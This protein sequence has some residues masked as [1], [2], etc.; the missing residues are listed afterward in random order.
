MTTNPLIAFAMLSVNWDDHGVSYTHNYLP[1]V[2]YCLSNI[3][4]NHTDDTTLQELIEQHFG[5]RLPIPVIRTVTRR[6]A[7]E[8]LLTRKH[9][10]LIPIP[11]KIEQF[12]FHDKR[13]QVTHD[14]EVL[15]DHYLSYLADTTYSSLTRSEAEHALFSYIADRSLPILRA[16]IR[17]T[18]IDLGELP[19]T[20]YAYITSRFIVQMHDTDRG[21]F[22]LIERVVKGSML[23]SAI[24]L[25]NHDKLNRRI[26]NLTIYLDTPYLIELLGLTHP[27]T[28]DAARELFELLL[29][30][31]ARIACFEHT[32]L[33][34][35]GVMRGAAIQLR[36]LK[37][38]PGQ[39][40]VSPPLVEHSISS[41]LQSTELEVRAE[42]LATEL[43]DLGVRVLES[44]NYLDALSVDEL[45]MEKLL[46]RHVGYRNENTRYRD[47]QS[48]TAIYR[49]RG[50]QEKGTLEHAIAIFVTPNGN[51]AR[52][53]REFFGEH[54]QGDLVPIC[55]LDS[56][57]A[58]V[59]WLKKP[60]ESPD[61]PR[62]QLIADCYAAG[63]PDE[64]LWTR[65]LDEIDRLE[66]QE[67]FTEDMYFTLRYSVEARR[68]LMDMTQ[69]ASSRVNPQVISEVLTRVEQE[70]AAPVKEA[71]ERER[72]HRERLQEELQGVQDEL[73]NR[74]D[75]NEAATRAFAQVCRAQSDKL[76]R[77]TVL[78]LS[79]TVVG[80]VAISAILP[81]LLRGSSPL[82]LFLPPIV[83]GLIAILSTWQLIHGA[84]RLNIASALERK[85]GNR[86]YRFLTRGG[87][88]SR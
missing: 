18:P 60:A 19:Q 32:L 10:H 26:Q 25:P 81:P 30:L 15:I 42:Q 23:A 88:D 74:E 87:E 67:T 52:A 65:Y 78:A 43:A 83:G 39:S 12:N 11:R 4:G 54:P 76:A 86:I 3:D 22:S 82:A 5:L 63:Y 17:G 28:V 20:K 41:G 71:L 70:H 77:W 2:A 35:Q 84:A 13:T 24:Y 53:S 6:A 57:L 8:G 36:S 80:L 62:K 31:G 66:S 85:I 51:L 37:S 9:G 64:D 34:T 61:L 46:Q 14:C 44:P 48:L 27:S 7:R 58:T 16:S 40:V 79:W 73:A 55:S 38:R 75:P 72:R 21:I 29:T 47:I 50:G 56:E 33:E 68:A 69:G 49:I 59:A 1:F 45:R